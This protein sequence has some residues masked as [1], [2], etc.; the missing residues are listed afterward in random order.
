MKNR[1]GE[2][3]NGWYVAMTLLELVPVVGAVVVFAANDAAVKLLTE[4]LPPGEIVALRGLLV[5][6]LLLLVLPSDGLMSLYAVSG[7]FGLFRHYL[8]GM[9]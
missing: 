1:V 6:A 9:R 2:E 7:L 4:R 8:I 5:T 3:N